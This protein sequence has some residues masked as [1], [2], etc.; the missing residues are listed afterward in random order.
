M[1]ACVYVSA[2]IY[3]IGYRYSLLLSFFSSFFADALFA[4]VARGAHIYIC[5]CVYVH[6]NI[7]LHA[8]IHIYIHIYVSA[9]AYS[10]SSCRVVNNNFAHSV[11]VCRESQLLLLCIC[12]FNFV[13]K[14][15][16]ELLLAGHLY[17]RTNIFMCM[18][19]CILMLCAWML[20]YAYFNIHVCNIK[21]H[22]I[23]KKIRISI[24]TFFLK[25]VFHIFSIP[26]S[27][28]MCVFECR[29]MRIWIFIM[30]I[31]I[32]M[33]ATLKYT[34]LRLNKNIF[35]CTEYMKYV[36]Q[37][38]FFFETY[39]N[40]HVCNIRIHNIKKNT[41]FYTYFFFEI[42]IS[43][44]QYSYVKIYMCV[45]ECWCMRIWIYVC[46]YL[47]V[48]VFLFQYT[49]VC[50]WMLMYS[51]FNIHVCVFEIIGMML[52]EHLYIK[53]WYVYV[54]MYALVYMYVTNAYVYV[55][56]CMLLIYTFMY[57]HVFY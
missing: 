47:N 28:Y 10:V 7:Y 4:A 55:C 37:Y 17:I 1:V 56:T 5:I 22:N 45:F 35:H 40:I 48:H 9:V 53:N 51:Y 13:H 34:T 16:F 29:C 54:C 3:I 14:L 24:R 27:I 11:S 12:N 15:D 32:F 46:V 42:R 49:C 25:Y 20:M 52:V 38:F 36:L 23:K 39:F 6:V 43:Y 26:I 44:V 18:C 21:I 30:R 50:I 31:W 41:Y 33:Y 2:N 19:V 57:V 8:H